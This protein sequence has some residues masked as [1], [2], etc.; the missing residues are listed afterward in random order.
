VTG[1]L[2]LHGGDVDHE[3]GA[4]NGDRSIRS[5]GPVE[6]ERRGGSF[7]N[8]RPRVE[9]EL[10]TKVIFSATTANLVDNWAFMIAEPLNPNGRPIDYR[11]TPF[12]KQWKDGTFGGLVIALFKKAKGRWTV[13]R[14]SFGASDVP[15]VD[16]GKETGG[17]EVRVSAT[18]TLTRP[19]RSSPGRNDRKW[20]ACRSRK[21]ATP[22][23]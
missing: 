10:K 12:A 7:S 18:G 3:T 17:A 22:F 15:W 19:A 6:D 5:Q 13:S 4:R 1:E 20:S 23:P 16:W 21:S 2:A 9:K 8:A 14:Y 11:K